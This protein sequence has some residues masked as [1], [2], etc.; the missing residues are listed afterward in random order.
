MHSR[1]MGRTP[2]CPQP[3]CDRDESMRHLLWECSA[4]RDLWKE[5]GPQI[6]Q[7]L[8]VGEA[9]TSQ[10]VLYGVSQ[11]PLPQKTQTKLWLT[12]TSCKDALW[13]S[14]NLLVGK[15]VET[16]TKAVALAAAATLKWYKER[17]EWRQ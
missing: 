2:K 10:L 14:R 16:P 3:G 4:A 13:A 6:N 7:Y 5:T 12:L 15:R 9:L 11:R 8:P 17:P 1:G